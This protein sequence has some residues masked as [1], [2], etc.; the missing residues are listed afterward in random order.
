MDSNT[1]L[2]QN[3]T[4]LTTQDSN[5]NGFPNFVDGTQLGRNTG[6]VRLVGLMLG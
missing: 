4:Y 2:F 3:I 5:I 6:E 1:H